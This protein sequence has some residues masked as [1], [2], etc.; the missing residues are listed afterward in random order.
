MSIILAWVAQPD[1]LSLRKQPKQLGEVARSLLGISRQ[2]QV[3]EL[4][5]AKCLLISAFD[6]GI[7]HRVGKSKQTFLQLQAS[8]HSE[9][10]RKPYQI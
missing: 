10:M 8:K 7:N 4:R 5:Q 3:E 9:V 6:H 1:L 2:G